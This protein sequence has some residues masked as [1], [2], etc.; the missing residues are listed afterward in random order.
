MRFEEI[1][2]QRQA[3]KLSIEEAARLLNIHER[4]FRRWC[5]NYEEEGA[6]GLVDQRLDRIAHNAAETNEVMAV[7]TLFETRY[8]R[9]NVSHFFEKYATEHKGGRSYTWVKN[10]LQEAGLVKKA[11]KK[12]AH[13]RKRER[14]PMAGM[15]IHQDGSSHE[16]VPGQIWDLIVTMDDANSEIYSMCFVEEEGTFSSLRGVRDVILKKGLFCS[17]YSDRGSHY[18]T[19]PKAGEKV[20]RANL[21]QFGRAMK[22]LGIEMIPAYS[23]EARGRSERMFKTLQGRLPNELALAGITN[24]QAANEFLETVYLKAHNE[25]FCVKPSSCEEAFVAWNDTTQKLDDILCL[26]ESRVAGQDNTVSYK[27]KKLQIPKD[28]HRYHYAKKTV[29]VREYQDGSMSLAFGPRCLGY[30]DPAGKL[31]ELASA[32]KAA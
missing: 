29:L 21:T 11:K 25:R 31:I 24:I 15:M 18:W 10:Q 27:S 28:Q 7:I 22:E 3:K 5:Q 26:Q 17:F 4:T 32:T 16:W 8:P 20:D 14:E 30:Y 1:Y 9:F 6:Q 19:T 13:R 2:T 12:G 23:P